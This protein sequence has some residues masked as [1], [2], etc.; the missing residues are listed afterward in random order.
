MPADLTSLVLTVD[1]RSARTGAQDLDR[2]TA[3]SRRTE[4]GATAIAGA[5]PGPR[6]GHLRRHRGGDAAA[7]HRNG[8]RPHV[9][10]ALKARLDRLA[11]EA[12]P[13]GLM[14]LVVSDE[15]SDAEIAGA[16][17]D[18]LVESPSKHCKAADDAATRAW[19]VPAVPSNDTTPP[20]DG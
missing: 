10:E 4:G 11:R 5:F 12:A 20:D 8:R 6:Y 2:L 18:S 17:R 13:Q 16:S 19:P 1:S 3:A 7:G 15:T 9:R 14:P